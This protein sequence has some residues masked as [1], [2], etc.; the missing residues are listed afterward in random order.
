MKNIGQESLRIVSPEKSLKK[1][2]YKE[3]ESIMTLIVRKAETTNRMNS[4]FLSLTA[5]V[6]IGFGA[7]VI[8]VINIGFSL[9]SEP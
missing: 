7:A 2:E 1:P 5:L 9:S 8:A 6:N 4:R 3:K